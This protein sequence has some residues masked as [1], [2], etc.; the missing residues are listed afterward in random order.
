MKVVVGGCVGYGIK[1]KPDNVRDFINAFLDEQEKL[2]G[3]LD[4]FL[5]NLVETY[6]TNTYS[7]E[8]TCEQCGDYYNEYT[9]EIEG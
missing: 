4:N 6:G 3:D 9:L 8:E 1:E 7:D 5:Y 2:Y